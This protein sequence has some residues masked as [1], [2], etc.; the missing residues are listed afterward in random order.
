MPRSK[1]LHLTVRDEIF[2]CGYGPR[3]IRLSQDRNHLFVGCKDG[4]VTWIDLTLAADPTTSRQ[5]AR[6]LCE[7]RDTGVRSIC[8]LANGWLLLAQDDRGVVALGW[9]DP[10]YGQDGHPYAGRIV[11]LE[12]LVPRCEGGIAYVGRWDPGVFVVA[13]RRMPAFQLRFE[14]RPGED[15]PFALVCGPVFPGVLAMSGFA[16]IGDSERCIVCKTGALWWSHASGTLEPQDHLWRHCGLE[17]PGFVFGDA[18]VRDQPEAMEDHQGPDEERA[19]VWRDHGLYLSTDEGVFLLRPLPDGS[20]GNP[21]SR[22]ARFRIDPVFLPGI[23]GTCLAIAHAVEGKNCLLWVSDTEGSVHLFWSH[24]FWGDPDSLDRIPVWHREGLLERRFPVM[25]AVASWSPGHH[26]AVVGQACRDDRIVVSW[27]SAQ[28]AREVTSASAAAEILSWGSIGL[29]RHMAPDEQAGWWPEALVADHIEKTAIDSEQLRRFLRNPQVE[30]ACSALEEILDG[31]LAERS[32]A[33][34]H[35]GAQLPTAQPSPRQPLPD[36][37]AATR[38]NQAITFWNHTLIGTTHRRLADATRLDYLGIVRWLRRLG[39]SDLLQ[40]K[41]PGIQLLNAAV[42]DNIQYA[43]KWGVFGST[44]A[45]RQHALSALAPLTLQHTRDRRFDRLV[46]ESLIFRRRMDLDSELPAPAKHALPPWDLRYLPRWQPEVAEHVAVSWA[47]GCAVY[48]RGAPEEPWEEITASSDH[49]AAAAPSSGG[50]ILLGTC[51]QAEHLHPYILSAP[52][53][54]QE[55]G[56]EQLELHFL[57]EGPRHARHAS[58]AVDALLAADARSRARE[59]V[60]SLLPLGAGRVAVGLQGTLQAFGLLQVTQEGKLASIRPCRQLLL[61]PDYPE[62]KTLPRNQVWSLACP[63]ASEHD[64]TLLLGCNDGQVW[65]IHV[66]VHGDSFQVVERLAVCR[67]GAPVTALACS[68]VEGGRRPLRIFAGLADG[69]LIGFQELAERRPHGETYTTLWATREQARVQAI[70]CLPGDLPSAGEA[71]PTD[72]A[73]KRDGG[74]GAG[75][76]NGLPQL[77]LAITQQGTVVMVLDREAVEE[78]APGADRLRRLQLPGEQLGRLRL[79]SSVFGSALLA[80]AQGSM[81]IEAAL[82]RLIVAPASG[83]P[84]VLTLHHPKFTP[85]RHRRFSDLRREWLQNLHGPT[86]D[87]VQGHLLRR[88]ETTYAVSPALPAILVR[89]ILPFEAHHEAWATRTITE[90]P[91]PE[92]G[93]CKQWLPGH[94]RPLVDLDTA[95]REGRSLRGLFKAALLAAREVED[96][97]LFKEIIEAALSRANHQL[98]MEALAG[99]E[100]GFAEQF[101]GLVEDLEEV[102]GAWAGVAEGL[103]TRMRITVAKGLLDGD[104]LWSLSRRRILRDARQEDPAVAR[105]MRS[106]IDVVHR[107]LGKG[108]MLLALET[109]RAANRAL[110]RLCRRLMPREPAD[111]TWTDDGDPTQRADSHLHWPTISAFYQAV[112]DFAARVAHA[113]GTLGEVAAHEVCRAYA[114]GI[115]ACPSQMVRLAIWLTE[116]DLPIDVGDRVEQQLIL[117]GSVLGGERTWMPRQY[118]ALLRIVLRTPQA[119]RYQDSL[120]FTRQGWRGWAQ[121]SAKVGTGN[122]EMVR[123]RLPF[124]K[125]VIWLHDLARQLADDAGAVDLRQREDLYR[126]I[127]DAAVEGERAKDPAEDQMRHSRAFWIAAFKDLDSACSGFIHL[128]PEQRTAPGDGASRGPV[129]PEVVLF[130]VTLEMWSKR[131]REEIQRR[132]KEHQIFARMS[133]LYDEALSLVQRTARRFRE[134]AAVQKSLVLGVLSHGLLEMLDEHLLEVW[135]VAQALDPRRAWEREANQTSGHRPVSTAAGFAEYLLQRALKAEVIPKSLRSLQGMLGLG[136]DLSRAHRAASDAE[137]QPQPRLAKLTL[138]GLFGEFRDTFDWVLDP[139][140]KDSLDSHRLEPRTYDLL[141]L[142][143]TELAQNDRVHGV[144]RS[145]VTEERRP[146]WRPR[147]EGGMVGVEMELQL[148]FYYPYDETAFRRAQQLSA[149]ALQGLI[150][151]RG[152]PHIPSHG[153]GLYLANLAAAAALWK[154]QLLDPERPIGRVTGALCFTLRSRSRQ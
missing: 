152:E 102:K 26:K 97:A 66:V 10:G 82:S 31:H 145:E 88:P 14:S 45:S 3:S 129:R 136:F 47:D 54:Q 132:R 1:Q 39:E 80:A 34:P 60:F 90:G 62:S 28:E 13:P 130:S 6:R 8:D 94:L 117:V 24:R 69:T 73:L 11:P 106:R 91:G 153:T 100:L 20:Q 29:L 32:S 50:R 104:T 139:Q 107:F 37:A 148:Y 5:A 146:D 61:P 98:Y 77:V 17:R 21:G 124:D 83:G 110:L 56:R 147:V 40:S 74:D 86:G 87:K 30:L 44:Y 149:T 101:A 135:E 142:T 55:S 109:L 151:P 7:P 27:Y 92:Q 15:P 123:A 43:R 128:F 79:G 154:L 41:R 118:R 121:E 53:P 19:G 141:H 127:S 25:R 67:L 63:A 85:A 105:A 126:S 108:D 52:A 35:P 120:F 89:W 143:L 93:P 72:D 59:S 36:E 42:E 18:V 4:S 115:L 38:A 131:Q 112:G 23:T 95:W 12:D 49:I 103:D 68:S 65:K 78:P 71:P 64:L 138:G 122:A 9:P 150:P 113:K 140:L 51:G 133:S 116:A 70:Y 57:D 46:Y 81:G 84:R 125:I 96:T 33:P 48:R 144:L 114:L 137:P 99:G 2:S 16:R 111:W 58:L 134:G 75:A 119:G 22:Q 76:S